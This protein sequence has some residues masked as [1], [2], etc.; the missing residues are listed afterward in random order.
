[1][2]MRDELEAKLCDRYDDLI[3]HGHDEDTAFKI[4]IEGIGDFDE[5]IRGLKDDEIKDP[6][7]IQM[8]RQ[9]S[10]LIV[11]ISVAIYILSLIFPLIF[12]FF[13]RAGGTIGLVLMFICWA[14]ATMMLVYNGMTSPRHEKRG[15]T[16][17]EEFKAWSSQ[18]E[19]KKAMKK[20]I[21]SVVWSVA[22]MLFLLLGVFCNV[23]E[24]AWLL[25]PLAAVVTNI[26]FMMFSLKGNDR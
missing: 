23:W 2:E 15:D 24:H 1:M 4:A 25:F 26:V 17:V 7:V 22:T 9:R 20:M 14:G 3:K 10:A 12:G 18:N 6:E 19:D 11:S 16:I 8:Q 21:T 13:G 5:L